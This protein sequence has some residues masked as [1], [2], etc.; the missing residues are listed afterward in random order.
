MNRNPIRL[1]EHYQKLKATFIERGQTYKDGHYRQAEIMNILFPEGQR[2]AGAQGL[3]FH[4]IYMIVL[5]LVRFCDN[6]K[7]G[8]HKDSIHDLAVY[9]AMLDC[10]MEEDAADEIPF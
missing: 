3:M 7:T 5:K 1:D 9:A 4:F 8:G 6:F 10:Y 2:F